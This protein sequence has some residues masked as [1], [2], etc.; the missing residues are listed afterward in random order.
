MFVRP[1]GELLYFFT[2]IAI[3]LSSLFMALNQRLRRPDD[4]AA[5]RY[6]L[7]LGGV[8]LA[9]VLLMIGALLALLTDRPAVSVLPP[10]ERFAG[11]VSI[12]LLG[13]AFITADSRRF[14]RT[15]SVLLI[16]LLLAAVEGYALTAVRWLSLAGEIDYNLSVYGTTWSFAAA[17]ISGLGIQ[18]ILM[19]FRSIVD[20]PLKLVFFLVLLLGFGGTLLQIAQ[21]NIIG[22][23]AGPIRLSFVTALALVPALT[24]RMIISRLETDVEQAHLT[25]RNITARPETPRPTS[26]R[27]QIAL[28][29]VERE[30][31]Q[32]L[33]GLGIILEGADPSNLPEKV[34]RAA[35][36]LLKVDVAAVLRL[37]DANYADFTVVYDNVM[38]RPIAALALN[39][40]NQPTLVNAIERHQQSALTF[41]QNNHELNDLYSRLDIEQIGPAY[42]QPLIHDKTL[43]AVLLV[44]L[45]YSVRELNDSELEL[46]NSMAVMSS[47]L[48]AFGFAANEARLQA[49]ESAIEAIVRG[50]P[51]GKLETSEVLAAREEVQSSLMLAREQIAELSRQVMQLKLE[52]DDE[53]SR[54]ARDLSDSQQ[55]VS[56]SQRMVAI[57]LEQ[58][59]LRE[60]REQLAT[61]LKEAEAALTGAVAP[62]SL[63]IMK[64][65]I[66]ALQREK[67]DLLGQRERLQA[68][69]DDL[70]ST[71]NPLP[72][73]MQAVI[74]R[75]WQEKARLEEERDQFSAR[76]ATIQ[77]QLRI[78]GIEDTPAAIPQLIGELYEQRATL[79]DENTALRGE[80]DRYMAERFRLDEAIQREEARQERI[81][82]LETEVHNLAEDREAI[83]KQRDRFRS[84]RE[85]LQ[86]RLDTIKEHRARLLA[87]AADFE[88][89]L[90][91]AH[92]QQTVL[93]AQI[94]KLANERSQLVNQRDRLQAELRAT[95]TDR[96]GLLARLEGDRER[97]QLLNTNGVGSLTQMIEELT[98]QRSQLERD[99]N[100]MR[101]QL[102]D[103]EN[104]VEVLRLR[105][106]SNPLQDL[107]Y[108]PE[109]PDLLI[110]LV[111]ELRNPMT[112]IVGYV[113]LLLNESAGILGEMQ[114]KSL[115]RVMANVNRLA[116]MLDDLVKVTELDTGKFTLLPGPVNVIDLIED[117]ITNSAVQFREKGLQVRLNLD[118][119]A[120]PVNGDRD[121]IG[122]IIGQLL[123]NA[124]LVSPPH[125]EIVITAQSRRISL[126][127]NGGP[128]IPTDCLFV[129]IEDRGGGIA[130]EDEARVFARKYKAENPLIQGLGDTGVG[131]SIAKA[132]VEAHGGRLWLEA[133]PNRGSVFSFVLPLNPQM[134]AE[135]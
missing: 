10:L 53:R 123:T 76:L 102:A 122:Q 41:S 9:W 60:E 49:E 51:P 80:L 30:S 39:L 27:P 79:R 104:L 92:E 58:Q 135:G 119:N 46:L 110:S 114:R 37:Q 61:R 4:R 68:Q 18:I 62:D 14:G 133:R 23:Y 106:D 97:L 28:S 8:V 113:E 43:I 129:S 67:E 108:R 101:S 84:E 25:L 2:V 47:G 12:I 48:L 17:L 22:D 38:K 52:L 7:A 117:T 118:E 94:Q 6:T 69:L 16:I 121:A 111:Q 93:R 70:R 83:T 88:M 63:T 90:R 100:Q 74:D 65:M 132:L 64:T 125:T 26:E 73:N 124:Y 34:V 134:Q 24:Y 120:P 57:N 42:F 29:P 71:P 55:G 131:L 72:Q 36:D 45:P 20:A 96:E 5:A 11:V 127:Q 59:R 128:E 15:G 107:K 112:S 77:D 105:N 78:L 87:Q 75:M 35:I 33:R 116:T 50:L 109:N 91:E 86:D 1:P 13:W 66:D 31:I 82:A 81:Q 98:D 85:E 3:S 19:Y 32:L 99:L 95:E 115:Q 103:A 44:A 21:G 54:A 89:Q 56:I 130:P 40:D 126:T